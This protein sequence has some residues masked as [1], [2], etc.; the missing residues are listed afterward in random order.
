MRDDYDD[1]DPLPRR[2]T[3]PHT[4]I[5]LAAVGLFLVV[6]IWKMIQVG[7]MLPPPH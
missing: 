7:A 3:D 1:E 2:Q 4:M 5:R 6:A